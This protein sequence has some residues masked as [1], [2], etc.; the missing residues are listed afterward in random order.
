LK[1]QNEWLNSQ[2]NVK[3]LKQYQI[4]AEL[5]F[6]PLF[7]WLWKS[8]TAWICGTRHRKSIRNKTT[9]ASINLSNSS[10]LAASQLRCICSFGRCHF[11]SRFVIAKQA[12]FHRIEAA[13]LHRIISLFLSET[14]PFADHQIVARVALPAEQATEILIEKERGAIDHLQPHVNQQSMNIFPSRHTRFHEGF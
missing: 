12:R 13:I 14:G 7:P 6:N 9:P 3:M 5:F 8:W 1:I 10:L 4:S 11:H 2:I